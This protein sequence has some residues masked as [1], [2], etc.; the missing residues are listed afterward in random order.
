LFTGLGLPKLNITNGSLEGT[1]VMLTCGSF[2]FFLGCPVIKYYYSEL[3][4][5]RDQWANENASYTWY[6]DSSETLIMKS[7][8]SVYQL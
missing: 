2:F 7:S 4:R 1:Q 6:T 5:G 3:V 8:D